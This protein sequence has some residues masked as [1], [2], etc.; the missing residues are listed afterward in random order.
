MLLLVNQMIVVKNVVKDVNAMMKR[1][2]VKH[3]S[4]SV[5]VVVMD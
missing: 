2:V 3:V 1:K 4:L 5:S